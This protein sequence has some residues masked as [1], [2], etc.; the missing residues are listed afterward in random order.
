MVILSIDVSLH[1]NYN[2]SINHLIKIVADLEVTMVVAYCWDRGPDT[3]SHNDSICIYQVITPE[4][5]AGIAY[6]HNPH[7]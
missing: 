1:A 7:P 2:Y 4:G 6:L 5:K 3:P